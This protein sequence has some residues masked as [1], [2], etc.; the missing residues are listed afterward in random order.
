[1]IAYAARTGTKRN[2][3][4][5]RSAEWRLMV[6]AAGSLRHEGFSYALDNGAWSAYQNNKPFDAKRFMRAL[7]LLG[8]RADFVVIPDI[9]AGGLLSLEFS[10]KWMPIVLDR[11]TLGL[12]PVQD[13]MCAMDIR[14]L[15]SPQVGI[16]IGG[17]TEWK[18]NTAA[19]WGLLASNV[20]CW[21]HIGRV[22]S[23]RR[24][25][26]ARSIGAHSFDGS[27]PS[28][29]SSALQVLQNELCQGFLDMR[30]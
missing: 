11:C 22:N 27:G 29:F 17:T 23:V 24:I 25:R 18:I 21:L 26:M 8:D 15:L 20:G 6:S 12:L 28:R 16:F 9:V 3:A 13:G 7:C 19:E 5:L 14:N 1:M 2:L 30:P 10:L 4:A